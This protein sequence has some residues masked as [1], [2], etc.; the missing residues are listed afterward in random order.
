M[1]NCAAP[2][3]RDWRTEVKRRVPGNSVQSASMRS[4]EPVCGEIHRQ[5]SGSRLS[6]AQH[7]T[8]HGHNSPLT[9]LRDFQRSMPTPKNLSETDP[10]PVRH[11]EHPHGASEEPDHGG[12]GVAYATLLPGPWKSDFRLEPH[13]R[14]ELSGFVLF[15]DGN[16]IHRG[17]GGCAVT[18]RRRG[19][20]NGLT[21]FEG[22]GCGSRNAF[23]SSTYTGWGGGGKGTASHRGRSLRC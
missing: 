23:A 15:A 21:Q 13:T 8:E 14:P 20:G 6:C 5:D 19:N 18:R 22:A 11:P 12:R 10:V 9:P 3:V 16:G 17:G 7:Q 1:W 2:I 4:A